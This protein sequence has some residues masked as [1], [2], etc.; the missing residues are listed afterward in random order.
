MPKEIVEA[1]DDTAALR[2]AMTQVINPDKF[3]RRVEE[4]YQ[5]PETP[6]LDEVY[7]V[8]GRTIERSGKAV[9]G[10][11]GEHFGWAWYFR[12][13]TERKK[14]E[15][16][17]KESEQRFRMLAEALPQMVWTL[18]PDGTLSYVSEAWKDYTGIS[19]PIAAWNF[20]L[21]PDDREVVMQDWSI[22]LASNQPF[23]KNI[24]LRNRAGEYRWH[25][26][27][28]QPVPDAEGKVLKW[29]GAMT[30][31]H[32]QKM[33]SNNLESVVAERTK[34]LQKSN[35]D[36][37]QFIHVSSHDLKE[38]IRKVMIFAS[39]LDHEYQ[40]VL[41]QTGLNYLSKIRAAAR[42]SFEMIEGV[43]RYSML[44][45]IQEKIEPVDLQSIFNMIEADFEV[46]LESSNAKLLYHD[47]PVIDGYRHWLEQLFYNLVGNSLKFAKTDAPPRIKVDAT[48]VSQSTLAQLG[49]DENAPFVC[50]RVAD[51]GIGFDPQF[52]DRIFDTFTRL[53]AKHLYEGTGMGLALCKKIAQRHRGT[54]VA[55][56][57]DGVGATFFV[58]LPE[59]QRK[60]HPETANDLSI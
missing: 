39:R 24:R 44:S 52:A 58:Y 29:V 8:D 14:A 54:I 48:A 2:F 15:A 19:E 25:Y 46:S 11:N 20:M 42:R 37:Q 40:E 10:D 1:N 34:E 60:K 56:G 32:E 27:V 22:H 5:N 49:L 53:N 21:H 35:E 7:F 13:I 45:I 43:L 38:P 47:L 51:N 55:E 41:P 30:D 12:D 4:C 3:L 6:A 57:Q 36:L 23:K 26:S 17:L 16:V 9:V 33:F 31:I 50:V 18:E 28:A 59:I